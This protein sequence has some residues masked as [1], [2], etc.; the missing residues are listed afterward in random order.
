MQGLAAMVRGLRSDISELKE[1]L[2]A[3]AGNGGGKQQGLIGG[4][5]SSAAN[6]LPSI[7][8]VSHASK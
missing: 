3:Q 1:L 2:G 6:L 7:P 5:I 4:A 8:G